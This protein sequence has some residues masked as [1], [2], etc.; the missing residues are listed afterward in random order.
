MAVVS[1]PDGGLSGARG[2]TEAHW[3]DGGRIRPSTLPACRDPANGPTLEAVATGDGLTA[4]RVPH[5]ADDARR[6]R[7]GDADRRVE[8]LAAYRRTQR[9]T[10]SLAKTVDVAL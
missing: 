10:W 3:R 9:M 8:G 2:W 1:G 6:D 4:Y 7:R 5:R